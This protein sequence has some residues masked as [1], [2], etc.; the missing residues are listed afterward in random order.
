MIFPMLDGQEYRRLRKEA[1][2]SNVGYWLSSP[3]RHVE[4]VGDQIIERLME[5]CARAAN[6]PPV[7]LDLG[8]GNAWILERVAAGDQEIQYIG[9]DSQREFV[10]YGRRK[11][12]GRPRC[13]FIEADLETPFEV[14]S[15]VDVAINAFNFFE[16]GDL[17]SAM[18]HAARCIRP[19]GC[20]MVSTIDKT[21]LILALS[22]GW[23][24]FHDNLRQFQEIQGPK[25]GFQRIDLGHELSDVLEYPSVL[26]STQDYIDH[27][28]NAGLTLTLYEE[29]V[30]TGKPIPKIYCHFLFTKT[31]L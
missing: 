22:R 31:G 23:Q 4:D 18:R 9:V 3:L 10:E 17:E 5:Q 21:Y 27:A 24:D 28:A 29:S 12:E 6:Q 11:Y 1:W 15:E 20:L 7:L 25:Y 30:F 26:Y 16:L 8:F 14:G 2:R 13:K 19:G